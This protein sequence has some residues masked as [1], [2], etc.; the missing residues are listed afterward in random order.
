MLA[1]HARGGG[2]GGSQ[3]LECVGIIKNP[4]ELKRCETSTYLTVFYL[5]EL[6][7]LKER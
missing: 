6:K 1:W 2:G 4:V 7:P 3:P 5:M